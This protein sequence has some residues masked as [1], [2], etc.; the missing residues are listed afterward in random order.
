MHDRILFAVIATIFV[1]LVIPAS[2]WAQTPQSPSPGLNATTVDTV[3]ADVNYDGAINMGDVI[4]MIDGVFKCG[5]APQPLCI[6]DA[7][8]DGGYNIG[9]AI[10][11]I[12]YIFR[13]GPPP[14]PCCLDA[15]DQTAIQRLVK[16][17]E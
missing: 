13:G 17:G 12:S 7:N 10:Y 4:F 2:T 3:C 15:A 8:G 6:G 5:P 11:M 1:M 16:C 9:D 14:E